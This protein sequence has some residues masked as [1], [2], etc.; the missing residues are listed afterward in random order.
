MEKRKHYSPRA[1]IRCDNCEKLLNITKTGNDRRTGRLTASNI[2][3]YIE[4]PI[5]RAMTRTL[6]SAIEVVVNQQLVT[7]VNF[8]P[9]CVRTP[10][11]RVL[12]SGQYLRTHLRKLWN[13]PHNAWGR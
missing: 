12:Q 1:A 11:P 13:R 8:I 10:V 9:Y 3:M 2:N 6:Q 5:P 4:S 7:A